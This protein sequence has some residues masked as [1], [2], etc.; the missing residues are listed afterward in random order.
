MTGG[1]ASIAQEIY[2]IEGAV[3]RLELKVLSEGVEMGKYA[4]GW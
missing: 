2:K 3:L 4:H 1:K